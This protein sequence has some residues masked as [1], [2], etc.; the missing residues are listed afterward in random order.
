MLAFSLHFT[1]LPMHNVMSIIL[2]S[3]AWLAW[4][5]VSHISGWH[6]CAYSAC[7]NFSLYEVEYLL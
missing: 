5:H 1:Y 4:T 6:A 7:A 2:L 3:L